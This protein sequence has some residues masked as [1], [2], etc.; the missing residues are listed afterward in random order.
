[1]LQRLCKAMFVAIRAGSLEIALFLTW[2][3]PGAVPGEHAFSLDVDLDV[4]WILRYWKLNGQTILHAA[5]AINLGPMIQTL[6]RRLKSQDWLWLLNQVDSNGM[7]AIQ[8]AQK[9][10]FASTAAFLERENVRLIEKKKNLNSHLSHTSPS[11]LLP[12][13]NF[14]ESEIEKLFL[15]MRGREG[16]APKS[17]DVLD[18]VNLPLSPMSSLLLYRCTSYIGVAWPPRWFRVS[19][20]N[21][22]FLIFPVQVSTVSETW[23]FR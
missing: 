2:F 6:Q 19:L 9:H 13:K 1:M 15:G 3:M 23:W 8:L 16:A 20:L 5:V 11:P 17:E 14:M 7:T 10:G 18:N 22:A 12:R 4:H 21:L